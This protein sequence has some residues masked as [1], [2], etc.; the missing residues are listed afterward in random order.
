MIEK[1]AFVAMMIWWAAMVLG[2]L[3]VAVALLEKQ[4]PGMRTIYLLTIHRLLRHASWCFGTAL[5]A[6][7]VWWVLS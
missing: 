5:I 1:L 4:G 2:V 6:G 7:I 3:H